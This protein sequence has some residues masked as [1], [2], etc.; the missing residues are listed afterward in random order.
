MKEVRTVILSENSNTQKEFKG[1]KA[2]ENAAIYFA[3]LAGIEIVPKFAEEVEEEVVEESTEVV[4]DAPE[5]EV[6]EATV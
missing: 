2:L 1:E 5:E 4:E 6:V 3:K